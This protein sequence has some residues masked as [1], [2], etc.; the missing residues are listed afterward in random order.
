MRRNVGRS[1]LYAT[2]VLAPLPSLAA[3][4]QVKLTAI[5]GM[6]GNETYVLNPPHPHVVVTW[7]SDLVPSS[8][9][10]R[11][12]GC[13]VESFPGMPT[14]GGASSVA[15]VEPGSVPIPTNTG[16]VFFTNDFAPGRH[17]MQLKVISGERWSNSESKA[18]W[19]APYEPTDCR[20][21]TRGGPVDVATGEMFYR[22]TDLVI[23]GPQP[24]VFGRRY[25]SRSTDDGPLGVGWR[26]TYQLEL[27]PVQS[28]CGTPGTGSR[29][30]IDEQ[31]RRMQFNRTQPPGV[32]TTPIWTEHSIERMTLND[33]SLPI[34]V[35]DK[36]KT[37]WE[38]DAAGQLTA[39][40]D[41]TGGV[42]TFS[43]TGGALTSIEDPF[44]RAVALTYDAGVLK[45]V[46]A[47]GRTVTY[48]YTDGKL[49]GVE[50]PDGT[51]MTYEYNDLAAP[52][53]LTDVRDDAGRL[54]EHHV[55]DSMGRVEETWSENDGS[56]NHNLELHFAYVTST[57]TIVTPYNPGPQPALTYH[58]D[59]YGDKAGTP[60]D[61]SGLV[62]RIEGPDACV[63]SN[64]GGDSDVGLLD[65][66][67]RLSLVKMKKKIWIEGLGCTDI[68]TDL[69][70][71]LS[72]GNL[73]KATENAAGGGGGSFVT[74]YTYDATSFNYPRF[75]R[76]PSVAGG[77][78]A[79]TGKKVTS[80]GYDAK[81]NVETLFVQGCEGAGD[82]N[83]PPA[84]FG[85]LTTFGYDE[86]HGQLEEVDGPRTDVVDRTTYAYYSDARD[87]SLRGRLEK[88]VDALGHETVF[89]DYDLFGNV[90]EM[91]DPNGVKARFTYDER[92]RIT[93][94]RIEGAT[95]AEDIVTE[96]TYDAFGNLDRVR[97]PN[98]VAAGAACSF[99]TDNAHDE[100]NRLKE[101]WDALGNK[102]VSTYDLQGHKT[103]E[104]WKD[105]G[106]SVHR[107]VDYT[108]DD[109]DRLET[110]CVPGPSGPACT[111][112][113]YFQDGQLHF[114]KD[115]LGHI[116]VQMQYNQ[117]RL[118]YYLL[119][120]N[121]Q[122][123]VQPYLLTFFEFDK[124]KNLKKVTDPRG[125][126]TDYLNNDVGWVRKVVSTT[127]G[128]TWHDYDPA[129]NLTWTK[130]N[131]GQEAFRSYDALNRL[132]AI[133][134][135]GTDQDVTYTYDSMAVSFGKGRRTGMEDASGSTVY[136]YDRRGLVTKE[137]KTILV[138][139]HPRTYTTQYEHDKSG[140]LVRILYPTESPLLRQGE[141][142]YT[143]DTASRVTAVGA[144]VGAATT[145]VAQAIEYAPF[146]PRTAM[147]F[148]NG[149]DETRTYDQRYL[150]DQW[151][152]NG[153]V[154][155]LSYDHAWNADGNLVSRA[156]ALDPENDRSFD[157]DGFHRLKTASG[158]WPS[159]TGCTAANP[160]TG[161]SCASCAVGGPTYTYDKNGNRCCKA[162]DS[163]KTN[164]SYATNS[165]QLVSSSGGEVASYLHDAVGN[166]D[167]V[168]VTVGGLP[169]TTEYRYGDHNRLEEV[170]VPGGPTLASYVYDG[171]G[172]RV[173]KTEGGVTTHFF[174]DPEG[175]LLTEAVLAG[176]Y[177]KD[178]V[179]LEGEPLGR[180]DWIVVEQ[181]LGT[182]LVM[183]GVS[184]DVH[185]DWSAYDPPASSEY[186]V[187]RKQV[188]DP[189]DKSF[190]GSEVIAG[191]SD[192]TQEY[193][194]PGAFDDAHDYDYVVFRKA[195]VEEA[196]YYHADHLG[197][198]IAMTDDAGG[199]RWRVE[200][201]PFGDVE[202]LYDY[203]PI[204]I[205]SNLRFPGQYF[206]SESGLHQNY[207]RDYD[208]EIGRYREPDPIGLA[209]DGPNL[210]VYVLDNPMNTGDRSGLRSRICCWPLKGIPGRHC[211]VEIE[212]EGRS[213]TCSL[214][215]GRF[216]DFGERRTGFVRRDTDLSMIGESDCGPW[217]PDCAD[218]CVIQAAKAYANPSKYRVL[219]GPNSNT[220]A[221]TLARACN[222][223][224]PSV[225][226]KVGWSD[227]P[228]GAKK[229][230]PQRVVPCE[231]P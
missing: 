191:V 128:T 215:G 21:T 103:A 163:P 199:F 26:H 228:A 136:H 195:N 75:I 32:S 107:Q 179:W 141:V 219:L 25:D 183:D 214:R 41:R 2:L 24:I 63:T 58:H 101:T 110:V 17:T 89:T 226:G 99:S 127:T 184:T 118:P 108:Y 225:G 150:L 147:E 190:D 57:K 97:D 180:V 6:A 102:L 47:G 169:Q 34:L 30:V 104:Q 72:D 168:T 15:A 230:E 70:Y 45:T 114:T 46:S 177:G 43:Y 176:G 5:N 10:V 120:A 146:G 207:F 229:G 9:E 159:S 140:N 109:Y 208:P 221:G 14:G 197:T 40:V 172:R 90:L 123:V 139:G 83:N 132:T 4:F 73:Q 160:C 12:D 156:D 164:Y 38:F 112:Y 23:R 80:L 189:D 171:D 145:V 216:D 116:P 194:D 224:P 53:R 167:E 95:P 193:D 196:F 186:V 135:P 3:P 154:S 212:R 77:C 166:I 231:L 76:E 39:I 50:Y 29:A 8:I 113:K 203:T 81:G 124:Q 122:P 161:S 78:T 1:V 62:S 92:D 220:F 187:R 131:A 201:R 33:A 185:A 138:G 158:P 61:F 162:E 126:V 60:T 227:C 222:L 178:Y 19:N 51:T 211:F 67:D 137:E 48:S 13:P 37:R 117:L 27:D 54:V 100:V 68:V 85:Y 217:S 49:T 129:G 64:L 170:V 31:G 205:E 165:N 35:E 93:E 218:E 175:V 181:S 74:D 65:Y 182:S 7:I 86:T 18:F 188:V 59:N 153:A 42:L 20:R 151:D 94:L 152:V 206:D 213:T 56:G 148:G 115:P 91:S 28:T 143:R 133:D 106:N 79:Y 173:A 96:Y 55:Y 82:T 125:Y 209:G 44:G 198:P 155:D 174:Y 144:T 192:P 121:A 84:V 22:A 66:D 36:H 157:Y 16:T 204:G 149:L 210:F 105:V 142:S 111:S 202:S 119:E 87:P 200:H 98:C 130:D 11:V 223:V 88:I 69:E 134:Y 71:N 52:N